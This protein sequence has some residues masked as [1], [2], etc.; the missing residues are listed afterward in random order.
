MV[1][2]S[3]LK[4]INLMAFFPLP[5]T[6]VANGFC[7]VHNY[8]PNNWELNSKCKKTIWAIY[9]NGNKWKTVELDELKINE[10]KTFFY[11]EIVSEKYEDNFPLVLLQLRDTP[12]DNYINLLPP[13]EFKYNKLPDWRSSV[14]F[15]IDNSQTSYQGEINPF[16]SKASLLTFH[17]FIQFH[18]IKNYFLFINT[19]KSPVYREGKIEIY[20][21][22]T[23]KFID[24]VKVISN[25]S[26]LIELD[27]Y[28]FSPSDLPVF[29]S[30]SM[31]GIPFGLGISEDNKMLSLEHTHPPASFAV[32]GERFKVQAKIKEQWFNAL[33]SR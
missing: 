31:A 7:S 24:E 21:S 15:Q 2:K 14:G 8:P 29:I 13:H 27:H 1:A 28:S 3:F 10:S 16:P 30:R 12:L 18:K 26:N 6:R 17:P 5:N 9:S 25:N 23:K 22:K 11:D 32:H 19:E 33:T 4:E 20:E